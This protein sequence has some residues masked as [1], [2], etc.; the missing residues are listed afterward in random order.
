[1]IE[2]GIF[3]ILLAVGY[4]VGSHLE[5]QHFASLRER[6]QELKDLQ[7]VTMKRFPGDETATETGLV[8]GSAVV[9][10]DYFKMVVAALRMIFGGRLGAFETLLDRGRREAMLRMKREAK[11]RGFDMIINVRLETSRLG[12]ANNNQKAVTGVEVMA[13]GTGIRLAEPTLDA[14]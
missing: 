11:D 7:A 9:S 12:N 3:L 6:E 14:P 8:M 10:V 5:G 4:F 1:M 2:I 13:Y